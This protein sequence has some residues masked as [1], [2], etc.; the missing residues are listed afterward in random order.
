MYAH[1]YCPTIISENIDSNLFLYIARS[2]AKIIIDNKNILLNNYFSLI[3]HDSEKI[4]YLDKAIEAL[5]RK[6][7][8]IIE[9]ET[10]PYKNDVNCDFLF[11]LAKN[12]QTSHDR[13]IVTETPSSY[14]V[15]TEELKKQKIYLLCT[16]DINALYERSHSYN[17]AS[18]NFA[19]LIHDT[20][21]SLEY[22]IRQFILD[23]KHIITHDEN[24][25]NSLLKMNLEARKY[26]VLDQ[27]LNG[28]SESGIKI[29][30]LDLIVQ[31]SNGFL[32]TIIEALILN[33]VSKS[34]IDGHYKKLIK[35]YNPLG[36]KN[37]ILI[38]YYTGRNFQSW[39]GKYVKHIDTIKSSMF[40]VDE[41]KIKRSFF[42]D[43]N[44]ANSKH[45]E[46]FLEIGNEQLKCVHIAI[47][48]G[49]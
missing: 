30:S 5:N 48:I 24:K 2:G 27:T 46:H 32:H 29:G 12:A 10:E 6:K 45:L 36:V 42:V 20:R 43:T 37:T 44:Y 38:T 22:S 11:N 19:Q 4:I 31:E 14:S 16:H 18:I 47:N 28:S 39:W 35:N 9:V 25:I 41:L 23:F 34:K 13:T 8:S 33:S 40:E 17:E 15:Y 7:N 26:I 49:V 21:F 3:S 1:C